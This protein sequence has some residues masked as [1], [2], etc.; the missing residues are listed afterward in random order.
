MKWPQFKAC[1][2]GLCQA[3]QNQTQAVGTAWRRAASGAHAYSGRWRWGCGNDTVTAHFTRIFDTLFSLRM[4]A[5]WAFNVYIHG[6]C[7][8]GLGVEPN[9]F[10]RVPVDEAAFLVLLIKL[11]TLRIVSK[12][13][14]R[15]TS[16]AIRYEA[17]LI[18]N[19]WRSWL[20]RG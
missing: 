13:W 12:V 11:D 10:L 15:C 4:D 6:H 20:Q 16:L 19:S 7:T 14:G 8:H 17:A 5:S 1:V 9:S 3:F 2:T 18:K